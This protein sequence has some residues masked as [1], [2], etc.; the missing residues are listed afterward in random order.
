LALHL[1]VTRL[2]KIG[3]DLK[4]AI[5]HLES[6]DERQRLDASKQ[7]L[8]TM[9]RARRV[10]NS[11]LHK[12]LSES[13]FL[14]LFS[15]FDAFMGDLLSAIYRK[16]PDLFNGLNR[17]LTASDIFR[18]SSFDTLRATLLDQ[19]M[20]ALRR[21]SYVDQFRRLES[22]F[23]LR[24]TDHPRWADFVESAQRRNLITHCDGVV[25][26][27]YL[28]VCAQEGFHSSGSSGD[29]LTVEVD[30]AHNTCD[31]LFEIRTYAWPDAM[32]QGLSA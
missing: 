11:E 31:V 25:S 2:E 15:A 8:G 7:I 24:L 27:Q 4:A 19:E 30:Y 6:T 10:F 20:D 28:A 9:A 16:K 14:G 12:V 5:P 21:E 29:V 23:G 3:D 22:I 13:L 1:K 17:S 32:A 26:T 18:H